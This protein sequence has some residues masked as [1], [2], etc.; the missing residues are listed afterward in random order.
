MIALPTF[1]SYSK[2]HLL[3]RGKLYLIAVPWVGALGWTILFFL[4]TTR[5]IAINSTL[6]GG[7]IEVATFVIAVV[8]VL[9][10]LYYALSSDQ[11]RH[12]K[13]FFVALSVLL[14]VFAME[15][16][17]WGQ[18]LFG[19][20]APQFVRGI[21]EQGELTI[22]NLKYIS[23]TSE[24]PEFA[25][26]VIAS[27]LFHRIKGQLRIPTE[28]GPQ[29]ALCLILTAGDFAQDLLLRIGINLGGIGYF[30]DEIDEY[31]ELLIALTAAEYLVLVGRRLIT[32][33]A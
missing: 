16:V 10:G 6:E 24:L 1:R 11:P 13:R 29:I 31:T 28:L 20:E 18:H 9:A 2:K 22:H 12:A 23:G 32:E 14:F 7:L 17:A 4:P 8:G 30:F 19:F 26:S 21:N 5:R 27:V 25:I 15:E 3:F 33:R